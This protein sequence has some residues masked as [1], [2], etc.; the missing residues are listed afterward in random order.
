MV[1]DGVND[2]PALAA[3][4]IGIAMGLAGTDV[5]VETADIALAGDDLNRVLDI[6]EL[7]GHTVDVIQQNSAMSMAVNAL[8]LLSGCSSV[9]AAP[10]RQSWPRFCTTPPP[11]PLSPTV[12]A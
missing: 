6:R 4:D 9:P 11:L 7:G 3:A 12:H 1:G 2:A 10:C 8:G 5:A